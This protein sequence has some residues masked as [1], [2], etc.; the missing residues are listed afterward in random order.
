V[1]KERARR[2]ATAVARVDQARR[3]EDLVLAENSLEAVRFVC[4]IRIVLVLWL[5]ATTVVGAKLAGETFEGDPIRVAAIIGYLVFSAIAIVSTRRSSP[6]TGEALLKPFYAIA[7]DFTF[8]ALM[9]WRDAANGHFADSKVA[10]VC[11][12]YITF[13]VSY[14][15]LWH[16]VASGTAAVL[17]YALS[18]VGSGGQ[19]IGRT[20]LMVPGALVGLCFLVGW[21]NWRTRRMFVNLRKRDNLTR[22]LPRQVAERI[23]AGGESRLEPVQREVT[24]LF[25]DIRDFTTLSETMAPADLLAFLD[26]YF[27][28]MS[29]I[30][31]GHDGVVNKF[32][33]DGM[34]AFWGVPDDDPRHAERALAAALNMR[35]KL[36]E[37]NAQR[38]GGGLPP[39]RIG[40]GIHTGVVA[41]GML[42]GAD[43]HEY[44]IIGDA[45]NVASRVEG[46]TRRLETDILVSESTWSQAQA[47]FSGRRLAEELVKGR[48]EPVV[49]YALD[50]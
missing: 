44:T 49:V 8:A 10:A 5:G 34:L 6:N 43:Q 39:I 22:F 27:G 35:A 7:G 15:S 31:K 16:V 18:V 3:N 12:L 17:V 23:L 2:S 25:T 46:L 48:A 21:A 42:G 24:V 30:V 45:V 37:M 50:E 36:R 14:F 40:I 33:G 47:G 38:D 28:H 32:L 13:A 29:Q 26:D 20:T 1:G 9:N 4:T 11:A 41:A 19:L